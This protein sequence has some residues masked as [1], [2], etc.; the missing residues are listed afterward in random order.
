MTLLSLNGLNGKEVRFDSKE[1]QLEQAH[2]QHEEAPD[3]PQRKVPHD[4]PS[5]YLLWLH[6]TLA[7]VVH[8]VGNVEADD[9]M[10]RDD[11]IVDNGP[12]LHHINVDNMKY[13]RR[14]LNEVSQS[15]TGDENSWEED[16]DQGREWQED[17]YPR[18]LCMS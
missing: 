3:M 10:W 1:E 17:E 5:R 16:E 12:G 15:C 18:T 7:K 13:L 6:G 4:P 14:W 11:Y 9:E 2:R 8:A